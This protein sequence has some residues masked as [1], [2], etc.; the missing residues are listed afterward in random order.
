MDDCRRTEDRLTPYVDEA[1]PPGE[2]TDVERHLNR[3]PPCRR[4]AEEEQGGRTVVRERADRL[5]QSPLPPG[6]RSRCEELARDHC[7]AH[8]RAIFGGRVLPAVLIGSGAL[9]AGFIVLWVSTSQS[10]TV[11]AAQMTADHLKC[12][13]FVGSAG[14]EADAHAVEHELETKYGWDM[15]VPPSSPENGLRLIGGGRCLY[16]DGT[17]PHIMYRA[18]AAGP[19][20]LFRLEG[21]T[22]RDADITTMG[23]RNRIWS[24]GGHTYVLVLPEAASGHDAQ[25]V[26]YVQ[27]EAR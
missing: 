2:R 24:R 22:R 5:R 23:H 13:K 15:H 8:G 25:L 20:S 10:G 19:V 26:R 17:M 16:A 6:L 7:R 4:S 12:F 21:V 9:V 1:L 11:L 18:A 3:C 14:G 27:Q